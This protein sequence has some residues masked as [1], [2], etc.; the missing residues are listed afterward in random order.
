MIVHIND[1]LI[2]IE[3]QYSQKKWN[4]LNIRNRQDA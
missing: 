4:E 2:H 1:V 3:S